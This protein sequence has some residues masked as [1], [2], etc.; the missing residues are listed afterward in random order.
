SNPSNFM[1]DES[2]QRYKERLI[3][4]E[5]LIIDEKNPDSFILKKITII[6]EDEEKFNFEPS[7]K[8]HFILKEKSVYR[9]KIHYNVQRQIIDAL[10]ME[11]K[12]YRKGIKVL[13]NEDMIGS[14]AP[15][16]KT[17]VVL[18]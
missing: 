7:Q 4:N 17:Y 8:I 16:E 14:Y 12:I 2:F 10:C 18:S 5:N 3:K 11:T 9:I 1:T 6:V 15:S 13:T